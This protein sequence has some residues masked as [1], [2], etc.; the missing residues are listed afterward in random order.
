M[1]QFEVG[2]QSTHEATILAVERKVEFPKLKERVMKVME[3][4]NI[5]MHL[6]LIAGLPKEDY[7]TFKKS[8]N[9]VMAMHPEQ[10]QLGFLKVLKGSKIHLL[11]KDYGIVYRQFAPYE[12]LSTNEMSYEDLRK[13]KDLEELLESFYNSNQF[14]TTINY[15]MKAYDSPFD[16]FEQMATYWSEQGYFLLPHNKLRRYEL[17]YDF[18]LTNEHVIAE[19]LSDLLKHDLSTREKPKKWPAFITREDKVSEESRDFYQDEVMAKTVLASYKGYT[20]KQISRMAHL[21]QYYYDVLGDGH[22]KNLWLFYDYKKKNIMT[23]HASVTEVLL[24]SE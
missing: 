18:G 10:L 7:L 14:T 8:F 19:V 23:G 6:D 17:L 9:D 12:V 16:C 1:F 2:V 3:G 20:P 11:Q 24:Q 22:K 21:E 4:N 15:L 5:H 13:L